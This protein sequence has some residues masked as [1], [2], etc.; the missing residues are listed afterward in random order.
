MSSISIDFTYQTKTLYKK[1]ADTE[2]S[3]AGV[4]WGENSRKSDPAITR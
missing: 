4:K 3:F 2:I 1:P